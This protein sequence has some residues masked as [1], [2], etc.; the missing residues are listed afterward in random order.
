MNFGYVT[1]NEVNSNVVV[2]E[3]QH[4]YLHFFHTGGNIS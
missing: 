4:L 3:Q 1:E 2:Y